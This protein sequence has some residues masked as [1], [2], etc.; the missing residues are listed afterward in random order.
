MRIALHHKQISFERRVVNLIKE[1]GGEQHAADFQTL[2]PL[3]QVPVLVIEEG[4][5]PRVLSQSL[6]ILTYLEDRFPAPP[7]VPAEPWLRA[8]ALQMAEMVNAGIQ[9]MQNLALQQHLRAHG[10]ADPPAFSRHFIGR[11]L[12]ALET[13]ARET[14]GR[15]LIG[16][17]PSIA[18]V[19]LIPQLYGAR[20]HGVRLEAFPTLRGVE[21]ACAV[22]PAFAAAHPDAQ[23]DAVSAPKT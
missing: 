4:G 20:R 22:L 19:Y 3:R 17:I 10:V 18:D 7:L 9:P 21:E 2:N 23:T 6:A 13:V 11:G 1:G 14:A 12:E 15:F 5:A 8:R 16:D